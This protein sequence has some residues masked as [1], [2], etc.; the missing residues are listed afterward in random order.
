MLMANVTYL[1]RS[2]RVSW[3]GSVWWMYWRLGAPAAASI[4]IAYCAVASEPG[5]VARVIVVIMSSLEREACQRSAPS[6][7]VPGTGLVSVPPELPP[8]AAAIEILRCQILKSG[9]SSKLGAEMR[10][11]PLRQIAPSR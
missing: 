1:P 4:F 5:G 6:E 10:R 11:W 2:P 7:S 9:L 8:E 3:R